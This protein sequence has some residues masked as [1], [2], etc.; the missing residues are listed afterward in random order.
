MKDKI[1]LT[2]SKGYL[3]GHVLEE[4]DKYDI[5][6]F[7]G[8]TTILE[9]WEKYHHINFKYI[10]HFG[11]AAG[12]EGDDNDNIIPSIDNAIMF[13]NANKSILVEASTEAILKDETPYAKIKKMSH[14]KV[15]N[16]CDRYVSLI[17]PRVYSKD[18]NKGLIKKIK[19]NL[20]PEDDMMKRV[21]YIT[22][23]SFIYQ[24]K[25]I[26]VMNMNPKSIHR[27]NNIQCKNIEQIKKIYT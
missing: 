24:L 10:M 13:A 3:G 22:I 15:M 9:N 19:N 6:E 16:Q 27:F 1:L 5:Y 17:L 26:L 23:K 11:S 14:V 2:G 25:Q 7:K 21:C 18:R 20:V 12:N 4:F 8:D